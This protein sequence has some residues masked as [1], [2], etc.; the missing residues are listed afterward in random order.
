MSVYIKK[1]CKWCGRVFTAERLDT[2]YCSTRC[3]EISYKIKQAD[4]HE[5]PFLSVEE[6]IKPRKS[7]ED[8]LAED[9]KRP[10]SPYLA[11][12]GAKPPIPFPKGRNNY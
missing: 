5:D 1:N 7:Y 9:R 12:P 6:N 10:P 4:P 11:P 8:Y 2:K 3:R